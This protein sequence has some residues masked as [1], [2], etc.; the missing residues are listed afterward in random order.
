MPFTS[1]S[2]FIP[3]YFD[4]NPIGWLAFE[5]GRK[6]SRWDIPAHHLAET[7]RFQCSEMIDEMSKIQRWRNSFQMAKIDSFPALVRMLSIDARESIW[8]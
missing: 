8:R 3:A 2:S 5:T 6:M 1:F 4:D 7:E